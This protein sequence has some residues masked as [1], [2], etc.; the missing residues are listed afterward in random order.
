ML[1]VGGAG[2]AAA[3]AAGLPR[4]AH[5][6]GA[7]QPTRDVRLLN[8][9]AAGGSGD[10]VCRILAEALRPVFGQSVIV[11]TQAGAN[12]FIA[13]QNVARAAPDG[14]TVGL[15]TMSMLTIAPQLPGVKLPINVDTDLTPLANVVGIYKLLVTWPKA[16]FTTVPEL[17]AYA[18][19]NPGAISYASAGIGSSPHLAGELFRRQAG[20]DIV[21]VPYKGGAAAIVDLAAGRVQMLI[22]NMTDFLGQVKA[23][24]LRGVAFGGDRAAPALPNLP[25]IKQWLPRYSVSNWFGI[26]GPG[27]LPAP[28]ASAGNMALQKVLAE[29]AVQARMAEHGA[30]ILVGPLDRFAAEIASYRANWGEVIRAAGIRA[31]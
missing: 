4:H 10:V 16:P 27:R 8:G 18:R 12:G 13:A 20:I 17:I 19:A 23:G 26:V 3:L 31:E 2:L 29:P 30:E 9:F 24:T 15:A 22:G 14:H 25:L 5:A 11:E 28:I 1:G 21:H 7:W 6:Q